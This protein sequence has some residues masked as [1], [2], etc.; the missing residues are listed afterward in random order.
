ME[1]YLYWLLPFAIVAIIY[2]A[3]RWN[4]SDLDLYFGAGPPRD[5]VKRLAE[6]GKRKP[7]EK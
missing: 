3:G 5:W 7:P 1:Q 6:Q 4:T 2:F